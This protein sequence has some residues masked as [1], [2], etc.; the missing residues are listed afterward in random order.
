MLSHLVPDSPVGN[1]PLGLLDKLSELRVVIVSRAGG[2]LDQVRLGKRR[3]GTVGDGHAAMLRR[4]PNAS[5][6]G[7]GVRDPC[8][9]ESELAGTRRQPPNAKV[10]VEGYFWGFAQVAKS[11]LG[12]FPIPS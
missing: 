8:A 4:G 7:P 3:V 9:N 5:V 12:D 11:A 1:R 6:D 10:L 2:Q